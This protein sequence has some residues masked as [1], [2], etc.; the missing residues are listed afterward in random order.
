MMEQQHS[1]TAY[2]HPST[3]QQPS[4]YFYTALYTGAPIKN[5][6]LEKLCISAT[7]AQI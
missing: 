6:H 7:I 1:K 2:N 5:N 3:L 4:L